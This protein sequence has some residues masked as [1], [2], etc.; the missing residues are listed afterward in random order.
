MDSAS[1][2]LEE[3]GFV[4]PI[5][6]GQALP[7]AHPSSEAWSVGVREVPVIGSGERA[8]GF[9]RLQRRMS[10]IG[11]AGRA[12]RSHRSVVVVPSRT[13]D[14]WD[15]P[16]AEAL[17]YEERMLSWLF[18]LRDPSVRV[19][20]VTSAPIAPPI[21]DYYLSLL[22]HGARRGARRRL[23]L[24]ALDDRRP[25]PLA[26]KL[27]ER[28]GV[29]E[30]IRETVC[31][32]LLSHMVTYNSG[33]AE[34]DLALALDLPLYGPDPDHSDLGTKSGSR[35]LFA[36][37]GVPHPL[38]IGRIG[39]RSD[40]VRAVA[41]LRAIKP[42]LTELLIKLNDGVSGEGNALIDVAGL[43]VPGAPAELSRI[44]ERVAALAP[45]AGSVSPAA[46][47]AKLASQGGVI[48]ERIVGRDLSSPS[49]QFNI[50]PWG[51]VELI[52]THDQILGGSSA[53]RY[54]G[55]RF[56]A[57]P[58]YASLIAALARPVANRLADIGVIGRFAL[59]FVAARA[60]AGHWEAFAVELN[61]RVGGTTHPHRTLQHLVGGRYDAD[62]A[63]FSTADG[64]PRHYV[65]TD[66]LED[67]R[68]RALGAEGVLSIVRRGELGFNRRGRIGSVFHMLSSLDEL[69]R[70][71]LTAIGETPGEAA[72]IHAHVEA[73]LIDHA[74]ARRPPARR[75]PPHR[76]ALRGG[77][78]PVILAG[79]P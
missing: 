34:R 15:E 51:A 52:S 74:T 69:G 77:A 70:A 36:Q 53:Q 40:A 72:A 31:E 2:R 18:E 17:A 58:A 55:C 39:N 20:Y 4:R 57:D 41:R 61:L 75:V 45:A 19:T 35:E 16:P 62:S 5:V 59:D 54:R 27:L 10:A 11:A 26:E 28:P 49:V 29:L 73:A 47:L 14:R 23:R 79:A 50:T 48:E 60:G 13:V 68:L 32:P 63:S 24:I 9:R 67:R 7:T 30:R 1:K 21:V 65:A 8:A 43:P 25:C 33:W 56:P 46:F 64:Q 12:G 78:I 66:Y 76:R 44:A 6:S 42:G 71:G 3:R 22:P 37:V 38:G